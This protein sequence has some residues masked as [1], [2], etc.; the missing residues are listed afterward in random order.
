MRNLEATDLPALTRILQATDAFTE[1]E[2][3]CAVE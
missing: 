1:V 3:E 2:G